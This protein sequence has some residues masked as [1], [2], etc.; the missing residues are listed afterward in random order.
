MS[1]VAQQLPVLLENLLRVALAGVPIVL[2]TDTGIPGVLPGIALQLELV[3][4]VDVGISSRQA[5]D[6]ATRNAAAM[7]D[8]ASVFGSIEP[9]LAADILIV[10][11]NPLE[12]I[13]NICEICRVIHAGRVYDPKLAR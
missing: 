6:G 7:P 5:L 2:G 3:M 8:Q 11:A 9:G 12:D 4:H 13:R 1:F 10:D